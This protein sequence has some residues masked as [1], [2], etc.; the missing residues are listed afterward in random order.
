MPRFNYTWVTDPPIRVYA[1]ATAKR[2]TRA[3]GERLLANIQD[4]RTDLT[5][6]PEL[7]S[8]SPDNI[9]NAETMCDLFIK[10]DIE[11]NQVLCVYSL[12]G[13]PVCLMILTLFSD[14]L[15]LDDLLVHPAAEFGGSIMIEFA[16]NYG[17]QQKKHPY[18]QLSALND[19]A[20]GFYRGMGFTPIADSTTRMELDLRKPSAKWERLAGKWR[21]SSSRDPGPMYVRTEYASPP[22]LP[23]SKPRKKLPPLPP[24]PPGI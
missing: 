19:T 5:A 4:Y 22:P 1:G 8:L 20:A 12:T 11:E 17:V 3:Y 15:Y 21:Y 24:K 18:I 6:P 16:I 9:D 2:L 7:R 13:Q 14:D 10:A 23:P